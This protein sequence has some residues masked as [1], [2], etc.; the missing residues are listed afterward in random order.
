MLVK[1]KAICLFSTPEPQ[2]RLR[3]LSFVQVFLLNRCLE[4]SYRY[5]LWCVLPTAPPR[6]FSVFSHHKEEMTDYRLLPENTSVCELPW[7]R[8]VQSQH[9]RNAQTHHWMA[10]FPFFALL[11]PLGWINR[12]CFKQAESTWKSRSFKRAEGFSKLC[13]I[14]ASIDP[15]Q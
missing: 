5:S 4:G 2:I 15:R 14:A 9:L 13:P 12:V 6:R 3:Q 10:L 7:V 8:I 11:N 1:T